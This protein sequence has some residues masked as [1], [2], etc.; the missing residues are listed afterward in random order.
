[1]SRFQRELVQGYED[2]ELIAAVERDNRSRL[3]LQSLHAPMGIAFGVL[4]GAGTWAV[5]G[6]VVG[7]SLGLAGKGFAS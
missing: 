2:E 4:L 3:H 7:L 1:M 6:L 5:V